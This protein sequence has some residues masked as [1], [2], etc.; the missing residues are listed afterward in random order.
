MSISILPWHC[1]VTKEYYQCFVVVFIKSSRIISKLSYIFICIYLCYSLFLFVISFYL[2][3]IDAFKY[4]S[5]LKSLAIVSHFI[6]I[7][8]LNESV[9]PYMCVHYSYIYM[10]SQSVVSHPMS[11]DASAT[12]QYIMK[13]QRSSNSSE[14]MDLLIKKPRASK[15]R[16]KGVSEKSECSG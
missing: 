7:D 12:L 2:K 13:L 6:I 14:G 4:K 11:L 3:C 8:H 16:R 9:Y 1:F 5:I 15:E 10:N